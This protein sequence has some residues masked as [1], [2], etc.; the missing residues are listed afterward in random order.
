[1][2]VDD[3]LDNSLGD[4]HWSCCAL[5]SLHSF[6]NMGSWTDFHQR[7]LF[8][9]LRIESLEHQAICA[10]LLLD[11][12][13]LVC[14]K[15]RTLVATRVDA[16]AGNLRS[17]MCIGTTVLL[18]LLEACRAPSPTQVKAVLSNWKSRASANQVVESRL[19]SRMRSGLNVILGCALTDQLFLC[20]GP[21]IHEFDS[22]IDDP[23]VSRSSNFATHLPIRSHN[24]LD[25]KIV[26][27]GKLVDESISDS[28]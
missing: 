22:G 4:D 21:R 10:G 16:Q 18:P 1:M 13:Q 17:H 2:S 20:Y 6:N 24:R 19:R 11:T 3:L 26:A 12:L 14:R 28:C 25:F 5:R 27:V 15:L 7:C 23:C 8:N 9:H